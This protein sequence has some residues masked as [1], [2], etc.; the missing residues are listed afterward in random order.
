MGIYPAVS[1][2]ITWVANNIEGVYK[3]GIVMGMVIGWGN[4]NGVVSSNVYFDPPRFY[5]G[6][7][8]SV[9]YLFFGVFCGSVVFWFLLRRENKAR[10]AGER[11][12][13]I[14][15]KSQKEIDAMLDHR[16]D[17]IYTL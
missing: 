3:R 5:Q 6:H 7:G 15:G 12:H 9:A 16:P 11:D 17:F 13:L 14:Q 1:L 4:L 2:T 8:V 10:L